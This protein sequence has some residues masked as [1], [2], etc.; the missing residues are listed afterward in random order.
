[1]TKS[2]DEYYNSYH[3]SFWKINIY[4]DYSALTENI[5]L[6]N[7]VPN[8]KVGDRVRLTRYKNIFRKSD[9]ENR[10]NEILAINV[11]LKTYPWTYKIKD[12]IGKK[13]IGSFYEK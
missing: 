12:V 7:N 5:E 3:P 9:T 4:A 10:S 2:V 13:L 11:V 6:S 8:F 1:M